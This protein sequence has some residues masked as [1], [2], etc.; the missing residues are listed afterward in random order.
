MASEK[1]ARKECTSTPEHPHYEPCTL[2]ETGDISG[3]DAVCFGSFRTIV[4]FVHA[5]M[6][7]FEES[8]CSTS[9][10]TLRPMVSNEY[11]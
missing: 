9:Q 10:R 2:T 3:A 7:V 8:P 5:A 6:P 4:R 11:E 1:V